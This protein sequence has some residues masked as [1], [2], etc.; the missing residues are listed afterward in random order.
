ML[1]AYFRHSNVGR[2]Q[3][4]IKHTQAQYNVV[5]INIQIADIISLIVFIPIQ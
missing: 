4:P 3:T 1:G 5:N 2:K